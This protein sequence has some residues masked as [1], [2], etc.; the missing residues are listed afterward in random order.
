MRTEGVGKGKSEREISGDRENVKFL[1]WTD[2]APAGFE[3][4]PTERQDEGGVGGAAVLAGHL[5]GVADHLLQLLL[6][7]LP[8]TS[9]ITKSS[10]PRVLE[11]CTAKYTRTIMSELWHFLR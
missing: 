10:G 1:Q 11:R 3:V 4:Y 2:R 5:T 9:L 7:I 8:K 6:S